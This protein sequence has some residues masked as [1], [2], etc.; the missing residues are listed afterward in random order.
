MAQ[1]GPC[2]PVEYAHIGII[3]KL[4]SRV[5]A[6]DNITKDQSIFMVEMPEDAIIVN[7]ATEKSLVMLDGGPS[8]DCYMMV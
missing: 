3:D 8:Q 6:S 1:V 4:F 7:Q 2:V 5:G